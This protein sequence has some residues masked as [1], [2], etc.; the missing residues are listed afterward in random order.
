MKNDVLSNML[1][2][3]IG[4]VDDIYIVSAQNRMEAAAREN[5]GRTLRGTLSLFFRRAALTAAVLVLLLI[6]SFTVAMAANEDFRNA[7][8][9]FFKISTPDV[10]LP[11]EEEPEQTDT[12]DNV[13]YIGSTGVEDI[14]NVEYIRIDGAFDYRDGIIYLYEPWEGYDDEYDAWSRYADSAYYV[15]NGDLIPLEPHYESIVYTWEGENYQISFD[16]YEKEGTVYTNAKNYDLASSVEWEVSAAKGNPDYVIITFGFGQ[17]IEYTQRALLYDLRSKEVLDVL[18]ACDIPPESHVTETAFS[19][20]LSRMLITCDGGDMVYCYDIVENALYRLNELCKMEEP[21]AW[22]VDNTALVCIS[23]DESGRYTC[24]TLQL[25]SG[26]YIE[27]FSA[28]PRLGQSSDSGIV[29]TGGR[30]GLFVNQGGATWVYDLKTGESSVISGFQYPVK[31]TFSTVNP[32]GDKIL[33]EQDDPD[34]EGLGVSQV[35]V[36]NL[37]EGLFVLF[38]R[39]GYEIRRE[40]T[41][42]WFD[43]DRIA[44]CASAGENQYLYLIMVRF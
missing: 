25:P 15:K 43:D 36:L 11:M 16:W 20:D 34:A 23:M 29:L 3:V 39:E 30:Y 4:K 26:E 31:N 22:F 10:V 37:E 32:A 14:V 38:D 42:S 2:D 35:G 21:T 17:Q 12:L 44:I 28:M 41:V 40:D 33:F 8:F 24:G 5:S 6:S 7:V 1:L 18:S 13:E 19:P 27:H 9:Q